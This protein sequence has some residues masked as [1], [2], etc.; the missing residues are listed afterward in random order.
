MRAPDFDPHPLDDND[1]RYVRDARGGLVWHRVAY[2][3]LFADTDRTGAVYHGNY[4]RFF[5]LGRSTLLRDAG[6]PLRRVEASGYVYPIFQ[7][8]LDYFRP[9]RH[10]DPIWINTRFRALD[11]VRVDFGYI[12]TH[13]ETKLVLCQGFTRHC[14]T[15]RNGT[16]VAIDP[17]TAGIYDSFPT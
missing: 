12:I 5:E 11:R 8:G 13:A 10:D 7:V 6:F 15:N 3:V 2:R 1:A 16:P 9:M 14:A 4:F 17:I